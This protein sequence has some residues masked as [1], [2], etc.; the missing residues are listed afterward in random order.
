[1]VY[2]DL[3]RPDA[4]QAHA[5]VF[6]QALTKARGKH[7]AGVE[8]TIWHY[9]PYDQLTW[10]HAPWTRLAAR[11]SGLVFVESAEKARR[12]PY[13]QQK[14]AFVLANQRRYALEA[15]ERGHPIA[16][17]ASEAPVA[18]VLRTWCTRH[19]ALTMMQAAERELRVELGPLAREGLL[20]VVAHEGWLTT[21]DL[22][23]R[24][25]GAQSP[26]RMDAFY[27]EARRKSGILMER[28]KPVGGRF[29]FDGENREAWSGDPPAPKDLRHEH[30]EVEEE[31]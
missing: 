16:Y 26:W 7:E 4:P 3:V 28:G 24:A 10:D 18:D 31:V 14:L 25:C 27:R 15:V 12:R 5:R 6:A 19:G 30:G 8:P 20:T 23:E 11:S 2:V 22:F 29:S 13:H 21:A 17:L 1:M 9:V